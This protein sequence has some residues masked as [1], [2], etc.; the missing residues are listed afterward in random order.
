MSSTNET[1]ITKDPAGNKL[2]VTRDF[3]APLPDVWEA[4]TDSS[5]LDQWWA[6]K[7][8]RAE[9]KSMDFKVGGLWLYSM[10]G[11]QGE[12]S[13]CRVD[14]QAIDTEKSISSV[15]AFC[16]EDGN[17]TDDFP[18]MYWKS[19]FA[20]T[21]TG[22]NVLVEIAF[23]SETDLEKIVQMGFKE[24]FTMALGNLDELLAR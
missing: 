1:K 4:W 9:T 19:T 18:K 3:N 20:A 7:P 2:H 16:D 14:F 11:P 6:P 24:G 17:F 5:L 22:T 12:R 13:Y 21:A 23:D 8:W 15:A 10:V